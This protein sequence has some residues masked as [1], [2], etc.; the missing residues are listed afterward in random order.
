[1]RIVKYENVTEKFIADEK[2]DV[3][4]DWDYIYFDKFHIFNSEGRYKVTALKPDYTPIASGDVTIEISTVDDD[5]EILTTKSDSK[6]YFCEKYDTKEFG[7]SDLFYVSV[8][9]GGSFT[10]M[11]DIRGTGTTVNADKMNLKIYKLD[12]NDEIFIADE[13]FDINK[14][15]DYIYFADFHV[16]KNAGR[17]RVKAFKPDGTII[18]FGDVS[19]RVR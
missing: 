12:G 15:W 19:I 5:D 18:A 11:L 1:L 9:G 16:F 2:F 6:L 13:K 17:Y 8:I 4:S 14:E 10:A 3:E 7:V